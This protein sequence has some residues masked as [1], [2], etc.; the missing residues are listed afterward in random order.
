MDI[1]GSPLGSSTRTSTHP[2]P[3]SVLAIAGNHEPRLD[4]GQGLQISA[5]AAPISVPTL[6]FC[7]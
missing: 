5:F 1:G 2:T 6:H 7:A 4:T 3:N